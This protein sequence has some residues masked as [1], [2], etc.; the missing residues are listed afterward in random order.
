MNTFK[1]KSNSFLP[2]WVYCFI[3]LEIVLIIGVTVAAIN[4]ITVMHPDQTGPSYLGSLYITRNFVA[5]LGLAVSTYFLRS[6][7]AIFLAL[8]LRVIT[9]ISD[10]TNSY[11]FERSPDILATIP[12]LIVL[13]VV[14]P[15]VIMWILWPRV[16]AE[17]SL[18]AQMR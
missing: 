3:T 4:D 10:F 5:I 8:A 6:Y 9:E 17:I 14:V 16:K 7:I 2:I 1:T 12:Y 13:M 18:L 11:I 15:M